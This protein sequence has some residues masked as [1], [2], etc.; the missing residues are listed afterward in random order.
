MFRKIMFAAFFMICSF[1]VIHAASYKYI[2]TDHFKIIYEDNLYK[3]AARLALISEKHYPALTKSQK[4]IPYSK[5][6]I[7]LTDDMDISNGYATPSPDNIIRIYLKS[8]QPEDTIGNM[9]NWLESVFVHEFTHIL[10]MDKRYGFWRFI[11][12]FTGR[13]VA[14]PNAIVPLWQLEGNAVYSESQLENSGRLSSSL[15]RMIVRTDFL[16]GNDRSLSEAA[17][18]HAGWPGGN[19]AYLYGAYF[20][21][22]MNSAYFEKGQFAEQFEINAHNIFPFQMYGNFRKQYGASLLDTW[23]EWKR[24]QLAEFTNE[25]AKIE[26][27]GISKFYLVCPY[28][29]NSG[30]PRFESDSALYYV[31]D[32]P[33]TGESIRFRKLNSKFLYDKKIEDTVYCQSFAGEDGNLYY[34][35]LELYGNSRLYYDLKKSGKESASVRKKRSSW[36][37]VKNGKVCMISEDAGK[38]VLSV[39]GS[40]FK[41]E[42]ILLES[43]VQISHCRFSPDGKKIAYSMRDKEN[44]GKT[45]IAV[46]NI[47]DLKVSKYSIRGSFCMFPAWKNDSELVFSSD[48]TGIFNLYELKIK[49]GTASRLTNLLTGAFSSDVSPNGNKLAFTVFGD[50]GYG[51]GIMNYPA[52]AESFPMEK[53]FSADNSIE[54]DN[55]AEAVFEEKKYYSLFNV[56]P[57]MWLFLFSLQG[58]K[59]SDES[60]YN[61][62][63]Y[64]YFQFS[65]TLLIH[66]L[67]LF[68]VNDF[69]QKRSTVSALYLYN[70]NHL[71]TLG[72]S[73]LNERLF[74]K[75][76]DFPYDIEEDTKR[77]TENSY[78][79]ILMIPYMKMKYQANLGLY[80]TRGKTFWEYNRNGVVYEIEGKK[81]VVKAV[82]DFNTSEMFTYSVTKE[83]G[84]FFHGYAE[85]YS[86]KFGDDSELKNYFGALSLRL[87]SFIYNHCFSFTG[88]FGHSNAD[89]YFSSPFSLARSKKVFTNSLDNMEDGIRGY[90]K[91]KVW[92]NRYQ[93]ITAEYIMPLFRLNNGFD[94]IPVFNHVN[95]IRPFF[96][97]A[98]LYSSASKDSK[99]KKYYRS[100]GCEIMF[101]MTTGYFLN[102]TVYAGFANGFDKYGQKEFYYGIK[103]EL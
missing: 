87:P 27:A 42:K 48:R 67:S 56:S 81:G 8:P 85:N 69:S 21:N 17:N 6:K 89:E 70:F 3:Y 98:R 45:V 23:D 65:D 29:F 9:N 36:I 71:F 18:S 80:Y 40:D 88:K 51:V 34:N 62:T 53:S 93:S 99:D 72:A 90:E 12:I 52:A 46:L 74:W 24:F 73:Y 44:Q 32:S 58:E 83:R 38:Y 13:F 91:D 101:D 92:G 39:C 68:S 15:A 50:G 22:Y 4:W 5:V 55:A 76:N 26:S 102:H 60:G 82:L 95:Y 77:T 97:A 30:N 31:K 86:K 64:S 78:S 59:I 2:E 84:F 33:H 75:E 11:Y 41:N 47:E 100:A 54:S 49:S 96:E 57:W 14:F 63:L 94:R 43:F 25:K 20:V 61:N 1:G 10:N 66:N 35:S 103:V 19:I 16:A 79:G 28:S 37:D 7:V